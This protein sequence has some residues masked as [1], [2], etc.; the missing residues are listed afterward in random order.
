MSE[1]ITKEALENEFREAAERL[2]VLK[3]EQ[4][5]LERILA[6]LSQLL[7]AKYGDAPPLPA[8]VPLFKGLSSSRRRFADTSIKDAL[9]LI[10]HERRK[11]MSTRELF[12]ELEAGGKRIGGKSQTETV[13]AILYRYSKI[14]SKTEDS[15]WTL[16][17]QGGDGNR[18][19]LPSATG[20]HI[21][22]GRAVIQKQV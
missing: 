5:K 16:R 15:K 13:R 1:Q 21:P 19:T 20:K 3:S 4:E 22:P 17:D 2:G 12:T 6:S 18:E 14:F 10:L 8:T 7:Q 11:P 9:R